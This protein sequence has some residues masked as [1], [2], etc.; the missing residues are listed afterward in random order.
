MRSTA[1]T[2][3]SGQRPPAGSLV[4]C[5][6]LALCAGLAGYLL[7]A[8]WNGAGPAL[9]VGVAALLVPGVRRRERAGSEGGDRLGSFQ[10]IA[11]VGS[12]DWDLASG[13]VDCSEEACRIFGVP[14]GGGPAS[15]RELLELIPSKER[16]AV[17]AS[18]AAALAADSRCYAV[19]HR[20]LRPDG[21][22]GFV[23]QAGE[24]FRDG[25]GKPLRVVSV[26]HD[27]TG[28]REAESALF[29]EKRYRA[30]I[31]NLPQRI[32]LKDRNSLYLS[33]NS[34]FARELGLE[35]EQ[36]FGKTDYDLFPAPLAQKRLQDDARVL[37]A[38]VPEERD[39]QRER[40]HAWVSKALIP[41][42]DDAGRVYGLL[43]ILTDITS[44]KRAEELLKESE[45]R[46]RNTFEQAAVGICHLSLAG[47]VIRINPRFCSILGYTQDE[48]LGRTLDDIVHPE[49][50]APE[51]DHVERLMRR[52]IDNY[53]MELRHLRKDG[54]VVWVNHS[55]SLVHTPQGEP[56]YFTGVIEDVTA[57]REAEA[58]RQ[59]R[60][61]VQASSRAMSQFLANMSH[62]IRTPMNAVIGLGHL[63]LQ[64]E[65]SAKQR[66]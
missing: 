53:S 22:E 25:A 56:K 18:I 12:W 58:L 62:E 7:P 6:G 39:Q 24:L 30:L 66:D 9:L 20:V 11:Q 36:V 50:L 5:L 23:S 27:I 32:F 43:G 46:F 59:E 57:K 38:G 40:D 8:P 42:K 21:S 35:P 10:R 61:L 29:F 37:E 14:P 55:M 31:E 63:A 13:K 49:D 64:T 51:R 26:V 52:E 15:Y 28:R 65:L 4:P 41:L 48:L 2:Y 17:E 47:G 16:E 3:L 34:S 45:A 1:E 54:S 33:C 60:D 19:E 44:R